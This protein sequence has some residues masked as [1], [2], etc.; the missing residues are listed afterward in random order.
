[1]TIAKGELR[2]RA[3]IPLHEFA[4]LAG[5]VQRS[6]EAGTSA[7]RFIV[8]GTSVGPMTSTVIDALLDRGRVPAD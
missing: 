6:S 7:A 2:D 1:M 8:D 4:S 5:R 3:G